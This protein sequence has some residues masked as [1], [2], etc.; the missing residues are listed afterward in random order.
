ML[1]PSSRRIEALLGGASVEVELWQGMKAPSRTHHCESASDGPCFESFLACVESLGSALDALATDGAPIKG[2]RLNL[3]IADHWLL[4]D[5]VDVDLRDLPERA[6]GPAV[7]AVLADLADAAPGSLVARW[8]TI[9]G[10]TRQVACAISADAIASLHQLVNRNQLRWGSVQGEFVVTFNEHR[11][12]LEAPTAALAV[13]RPQ[14]TQIGVVAQG[15]L[16]ALHH[17]AG[18]PAPDRLAALS[19]RLLRRA[20]HE[21]DPAMRYLADAPQVELGAPWCHLKAATRASLA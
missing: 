21:P 1:L 15:V 4:Y 17:E 2:A 13:M 5:I 8:Q 18:L 16:A 12:E 20:G 6:A 14:G 7:T 11:S 19:E 3:V 10:T 9:D